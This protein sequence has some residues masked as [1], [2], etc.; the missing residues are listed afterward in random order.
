M[1]SAYQYIFL[2]LLRLEHLDI[3]TRPYGIQMFRCLDFKAL[4]GLYIIYQI[5]PDLK[6]QPW[7]FQWD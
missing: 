1:Q 5:F 3:T 6:L 4:M 7:I 2:I